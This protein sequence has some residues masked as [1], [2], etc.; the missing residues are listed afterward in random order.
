MAIPCTRPDRNINSTTPWCMSFNTRSGTGNN[1]IVDTLTNHI[2]SPSHNPLLSGS[3]AVHPSPPNPDAPSPTS[4]LQLMP[5]LKATI[6]P[7]APASPLKDSDSPLSSTQQR[8]PS[9]PPTTTH[10]PKT[11]PP[12]LS[13]PSLPVAHCT[14]PHMTLAQS[15][16][17]P[18][19][20]DALLVSE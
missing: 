2:P 14:H 7:S 5:T 18:K 9:H 15:D 19:A 17:C 16:S 4:R 12:P 10:Q 20:R 3:T 8:T 13:P 11:H 1:V 6:S